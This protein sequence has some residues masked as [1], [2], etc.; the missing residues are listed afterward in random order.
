MRNVQG[1]HTNLERQ[2][3]YVN[4]SEPPAFLEY[5]WYVSLAYAMLGEVWGIVIPSV[6]GIILVLIAVGC[7]LSVG[8]SFVRVYEPA[9]WGF[10]TA[11]LIII[12]QFLFHTMGRAAWSE[13]IALVG[14]LALLII[15]QAL[16]LRPYFLQRFALVALG[17][18]VACLPYIKMTNI[19]GVVRTW[20]AGGLSNPNVLGQ[21]FG[22]CAVYCIFWGLHCRE[23]RLRV[24][25]W[26]MACGCLFIVT[27]TV[28]RAPLA[29]VA[30][31]CIVGLR[32]SVKNHI[33]PLAAFIVLMG[34][35]YVAGVF[36]EGIRSY[37][38][39][40]TEESGRERLWPLALERVFESPWIGS[41][42]DNIMLKYN[43]AG[44][45]VN[46]HNGL[47]HIAIGAGV[48][49]LICFLS[50]LARVGRDTFCIMR[51]SSEGAAVVLPPLVIY[52]VIE[53]MVLDFTFMSPW[54]AVIFALTAGACQRAARHESGTAVGRTHVVS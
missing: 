8:S 2:P 4:T 54:T 25:F 53:I 9:A 48:F 26:L 5:A 31:A 30:L 3:E 18:G 41:G 52:T 38:S 7:L 20:G 29:A 51:R 13:G 19:G 40:G 17:I 22:F 33:V 39:R 24:G 37:T 45:L 35:A 16:S 11:M 1:I 12:I 42:L 49:P 6:G 27:L 44:R 10:C 21:W 34:I 15:V 43:A 28:S 32:A 14:W 36:D 50:Y 46:P 23:T 47:L